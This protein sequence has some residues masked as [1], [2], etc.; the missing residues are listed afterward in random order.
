MQSNEK[1]YLDHNANCGRNSVGHQLQDPQSQVIKM[2]ALKQIEICVEY[3]DMLIRPSFVGQVHLA[4]T[5]GPKKLIWPWYHVRAYCININIHIQV[6]EKTI[7]SYR[8]IIKT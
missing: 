4:C 8:T 7:L 1:K 5:R 2:Y 3:R 6:Y